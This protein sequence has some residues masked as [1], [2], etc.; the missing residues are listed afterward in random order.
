M[1]LAHS[2]LQPYI[3]HS[4]PDFKIDATL[5]ACFLMRFHHNL[6]APSHTRGAWLS[7]VTIAG[8]YFLGGFV[9]LI[10]YL[11]VAEVDR[12]FCW[13]LGIMVVALF[14]FGCGK[15]WITLRGN[16]VLG[17]HDD[18]EWAGFQ[19]RPSIIPLIKGGAQMVVLGSIAAAAAMGLVQL[20]D[21]SEAIPAF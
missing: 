20:F 19:G 12:A 8:G 13:S 11:F 21:T 7:A 10:P 3:S 17:R 2:A 9:P 14:M 15:S 18:P 1:K 16:E 4:C 5:L 6:P